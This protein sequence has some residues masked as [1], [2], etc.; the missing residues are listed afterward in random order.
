MARAYALLMLVV[1]MW[2]SNAVIGYIL[3]TEFPPMLLG[4]TRLFIA[5]LFYLA[6]LF[7]SRRMIRLKPRDLLGF[8]PFAFIGIILNNITY[9]TGL[10]TVYPTTSA[11]IIALTPATA[12]ILAG[13]FLK[14]KITVR[15]AVGSVVAF[16]GVSFVVGVA[17]GFHFSVGVYWTFLSMIASSTGL[18][19]IRRLTALYDS[20]ITTAYGTW[21]G[22]IFYTPIAFAGE[23]ASRMSTEPWAWLLL[24]ASAILMQ[25]LSNLIWN[26][27][28]HYVGVG[29]SAV[30][31]NL[32]PFVAM[33]ASFFI[34]GIMVT[35][36]QIL[37]SFLIIGGVMLATVH[38]QTKS[39]RLRRSMQK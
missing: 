17:D 19:L 9:Y 31:L 2:G 34:L 4:V 37:G 6:L 18:I 27:Q 7:W 21:L 35:W 13:I 24:I 38:F 22:T 23:S 36:E 20:V 28:M 29:K 26:S 39:S 8:L 25:G 1:T 30:F 5:S 32:E 3:V 12:A 16:V 10:E 11:L 33:A 14:E 15:M